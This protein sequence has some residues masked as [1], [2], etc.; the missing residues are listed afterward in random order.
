MALFSPLRLVVWLFL[1]H[2]P[3]SL[4]RRRK[5]AAP[6]KSSVAT[7]RPNERR[8]PLRDLVGVVLVL[9]WAP[10]RLA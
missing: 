9:L 6:V 2:V 3:L 10:P 4:L 1:G 5:E 8:A 7:P